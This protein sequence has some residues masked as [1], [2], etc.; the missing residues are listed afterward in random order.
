MLQRRTTRRSRANHYIFN[1]FTCPLCFAPAGAAPAH[2]ETRRCGA[3]LVVCL[4]EVALTFNLVMALLP[5]ATPI[6]HDKFF[7]VFLVE[8]KL[9]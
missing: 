8:G 9:Q 6:Q 2:A 1:I 4:L 3:P 5:H 7:E